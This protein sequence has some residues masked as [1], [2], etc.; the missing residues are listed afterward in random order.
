MRIS[1]SVCVLAAALT[2]ASADPSLAQR[3]A[4]ERSYNVGAAPTLDVSTIRGKIDVSVG[5][6]DRILVRG[7]ATVRW[8]MSVPTTAYELAKKVAADP[9][10]QQESDTIRLR[11]PAAADEQQ[12]LTVAYEVS[13]PRGTVVRTKSDSGATT[14]TGVAGHVSVRTES[15]A[16]DVRDL[17]GGAEV[18]TASGEVK[19]DTVEGDVNVSTRSSRVILRNLGAGLR[20]RTQSGAVEGS[21]RGRGNV[22]VGT[23][24]SAIELI[25]VNGALVATS[26]SGRIRVSGLPTAPWQVTSGSGSFDLDFDSEAKLNLEARSGSG[27]VYVD[28]ARLQGSSSKS[29]ASGTIGGGGPLVRATSRSGSIRI[30]LR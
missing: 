18:T 5:E 27:T 24:S 23:G 8:G 6:A 16:I 19:A 14:V 15:A 28:E 4:F 25:G 3:V 17:G 1:A 21:L 10:I 9:P 2:T 26:N 29:V 30:G 22:D 7:T 13:V 20:V 12:A 11:P